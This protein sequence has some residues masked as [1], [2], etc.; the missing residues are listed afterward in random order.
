MDWAAAGFEPGTVQSSQVRSTQRKYM[1]KEGNRGVRWWKM[2][3]NMFSEFSWAP[4]SGGGGVKQVSVETHKSL[5]HKT[6]DIICCRIPL[7]PSLIIYFLWVYPASCFKY[8]LKHVK[9]NNL[10][11]T[12][13]VHHHYVTFKTHYMYTIYMY[14][15]RPHVAISGHLWG[16]PWVIRQ[17]DSF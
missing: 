11:S 8:I 5:Y 16:Q 10:S 3:P 17:H 6:G 1:V 7:F 12:K 2:S 14:N 9:S 4:M 15:S 13:N